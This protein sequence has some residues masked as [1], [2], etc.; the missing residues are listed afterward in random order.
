MIKRLYRLLL[1]ATLL[2][3]AL[4]C[5]LLGQSSGALGLLVLGIT[6]ELLFWLQ[7]L[8]HHTSRHKPNQAEHHKE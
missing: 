1:L 2:L 4:I 5:Y 6:L 3:A 8:S 7:L